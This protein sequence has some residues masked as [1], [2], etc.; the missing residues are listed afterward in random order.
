MRQVRARETV[1]AWVEFKSREGRKL[2]WCQDE[3]AGRSRIRIL[4]IVTRQGL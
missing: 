3:W 1:A 4:E 2:L